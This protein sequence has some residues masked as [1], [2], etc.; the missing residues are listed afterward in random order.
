MGIFEE[1]WIQLSENNADF[2]ADKN[3]KWKS[4][5]IICQ[6]S[7]LLEM[8]AIFPLYFYELFYHKMYF[9]KQRMMSFYQ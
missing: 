7:I 9:F 3:M 5:K 4:T 8:F 6:Q 2:H 1:K